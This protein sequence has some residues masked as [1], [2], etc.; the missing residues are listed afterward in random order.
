LFEPGD[1]AAAVLY[2]SGSGLTWTFA[3]ALCTDFSLAVDIDTE[4]VIGW[5][6][7]WGADG[8]YTSP[9]A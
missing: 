1:I 8:E 3:R 9:A 7:E 2:V 4:E 6:S 5:T